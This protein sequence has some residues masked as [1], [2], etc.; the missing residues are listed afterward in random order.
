MPLD[1]IIFLL[2]CQASL[3]DRSPTATH[4]S[5]PS[6]VTQADRWLVRCNTID[7]P[8][9]SHP[10]IEPKSRQLG[11]SMARNRCDAIDY[12]EEELDILECKSAGNGE[13]IAWSEIKREVGLD[14]RSCVYQ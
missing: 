4:R 3:S 6:P 8:P 11:R 10:P 9:F 7:R 2:T 14:A 13:T 5:N 12:I 1:K